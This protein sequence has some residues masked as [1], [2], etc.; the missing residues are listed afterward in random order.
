MAGMERFTQ[1][2]R[3]VLSLAHQEAER[4]HQNYIGTEHLLLGMM[5]EE[6]GVAGR[7]LRELGLDAVRME[8][9][10]I[11]ITGVGTETSAK[12]DLSPGVQRAL[13]NAVEEARK[14]GHHYIGTEHLLLGLVQLGEGVALDVLRK[15]GVSAEQIRRQTRRVLDEST[16]TTPTDQSAKRS[17][18]GA[19]EQT[20]KEAGKGKTP[21]VDQLAT[22]L[23]SLAEENK[24]DPV[25]G[26]QM[27]IERV[28]QI[29][30]RRNKNNPA[31]IGEPGVGKTAIV[32]GLAQR[33]V[34]ND[35]PAPL[36]NKRVMQ[37][38]VGSLVAG[39]MYRGQ[40]EER[41]KRV[42]DELKSSGAIL[43]IDELHM[44]VGAGAAGSSV[45][46]ANILKPALSRGELQVI[47]ATTMDEYRKYIE[48]DAALE[49][50]FQPIMVDEP[51]VDETIEILRGVRT[52]Y[53]EHHRL[54]ISDEALDAAAHLS[55]R[56]VTERF[57][58]DK[59]IDL[60]DESSSRVRMYKSQ[61]AKTAKELM[62]QLK[63][64]RQEHALALED[65][66]A[67]DAQDT[68]ERMDELERQL[69]FLRTGWD[70]ASS[71]TVT[72][73]DIA[74]VVA[75]W[76]G[77]PVMQIAQ[78]ESERLLQMEGDLQKHIIGQDEAIQAISKAVRR[79]RAGL[80][81]PRR[82]IGS[83]MFLGPTGVGKTELTKALARF[84]FGSE[85]ALIQLDM[86]EFMERHTV[87]RLVGAPP[88]YVGYDEAGQLTEALRRRPYS[89]VVF[90]EV[91]KAHPEAHNMLLQI[92]EEG[93]LSD[94]RGRKVDFRNAIV[95]MTSNIGAE[96]IKRQTSLGFALKQDEQTEERLA[97]EDMRKKLMDSLKR[98][99][100]PEFI[101][102]LDSVI[103]FRALSK[104]DIQEIVK[105]EL[106]K[107]S[108]RLKDHDISLIATPEAL[109]KLA[110][111]GY[112]PEMG[113]RPL[114]RI[115]QQKVEDVLSDALLSGTFSDGDTI[116][117][118]YR[119]DEVV[120]RREV[121]K[122]P[123]TEGVS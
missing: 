115:I 93:H 45:D 15:L 3:R 104:E 58:P 82:P 119:E 85:D 81:D 105:L 2:A 70:R 120:L 74:E 47:G 48:S 110:E 65:G 11:R 14:M 62:T 61:A 83:F 78:A 90:D 9:V 118:D 79:A 69:D 63:G 94:A 60:I 89:I 33:I 72:S 39:T 116:V 13:E 96:M 68:Q 31:L 56:Y 44:L 29:L 57:L 8:E 99:F 98:V 6:G 5:K 10:I 109:D 121:E 100:R 111:L 86:S 30:A 12:L 91:E 27:E 17:A 24:L 122:E 46:A 36:M 42:I 64:L 40:F 38:D 4:M 73:E 71:P 51:T 18:V 76:T 92:M 67:D 32:E 59:A 1:R 113:A 28:I 49:R 35:V 114:K 66:R 101:N 34:E 112:D 107:V 19:G 103:V 97:Y 16:H 84:M 7:V 23:T 21:M 26:R 20:S 95:V 52:A 123:E 75:M 22:D 106:D 87:S 43:F 102:R 117:V 54:T 88:G 80:K 53:E 50:R 108:E 77:V 41:L 55:A 37:L 25:I